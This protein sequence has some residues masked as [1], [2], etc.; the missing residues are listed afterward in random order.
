M[1]TLRQIWATA[2]VTCNFKPSVVAEC[3]FDPKPDVTT[4]GI[5][6]AS[7]AMPAVGPSPQILNTSV[8]NL[9][10]PQP[11]VIISALIFTRGRP[12]PL[13]LSQVKVSHGGHEYTLAQDL[14]VIDIAIDTTAA[15]FVTPLILLPGTFYTAEEQERGGKSGDDWT[16]DRLRASRLPSS[17]NEFDAVRNIHHERYF[18]PTSFEFA[19]GAQLIKRLG[20]CSAAEI[21]VIFATVTLESANETFHW[22]SESAA[23]NNTGWSKIDRRVGFSCPQC[24]VRNSICRECDVTDHFL[25]KDYSRPFRRSVLSI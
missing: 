18:K 6:L 12:T 20:L 16:G 13:R 10:A 25:V 19:P 15:T 4:D 3:A 2:I 22:D 21:E 24:S 17:P 11:E 23:D 8:V 5:A 9:L 14:G 7:A 1:L